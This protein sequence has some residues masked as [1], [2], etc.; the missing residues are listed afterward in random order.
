MLEQQLDDLD[1]VL[2]AGNVEGREPIKG[3]RIRV[4]T[5]VQEQFRHPHVA[6]VG[7]YVQRG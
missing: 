5:P 3:S 6:T 2:L 4:R 1:P 7:S